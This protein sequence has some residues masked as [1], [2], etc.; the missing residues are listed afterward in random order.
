M[1]ELEELQIICDKDSP[2]TLNQEILIKAVYSGKDKIEYKFIIGNDGVWNTVQDFS[3]S[4]I[5]KWNPKEEGNYIIMVQGKQADSRKSFHC[6]VKKEYII[7]EKKK[8][9]LIDDIILEKECLM[10]GEKLEVE[11]IGSE[12]PLLFRF[13]H[14]KDKDWE[15]IKDYSTDNKLLYTVN[16]E[17]KQEIL[18]ECK[19]V[20]ST[21]VF[22]EFSTITFKAK[23]PNQ[24]EISNFKC[25]TK[26]L[27]VNE[28]LIFKVE[29]T[30]DEK[31]SLLYKFLKINKEGKAI[32]IQDYSSKN[33]VSFKETEEGEYKLLCMVRDMLSVKE[34]DDRALMVYKVK[35]YTNVKINKFITD[36]NSP[37]INGTLI[38]LKAEAEGGIELLY[39]YIIEGPIAYDSGYISES[40]YDWIPSLEG[41][42]ILTLMCKDKSF[43]GE[44]EERRTIK[45]T[46]DKKA[47]K[48]VKLV[49]IVVSNENKVLV[50]QPVNIKVLAEGGIKLKYSFTVYCNGE[51]KEEIPFS[52]SNWLNF[53][54][55]EKG[56]YQVEIKVKDKYTT[57]EY[58]SHTF[59]YLKA[60]EYIPGEIDYVLLPN[61]NNYLVD[62]IIDIEVIVQNT[63]NVLIRYVTKINGYEIEDT[64]FIDSK[65]LQINPKCSG[66]YT[67][68]MYAK[69]KKCE[70]EYDSKK[71]ISFYVLERA[72]IINTKITLDKEVV[73]VNKEITF[74]AE[75][76]GGKEVC[77]EFYIM[78][79]DNW[80]KVQSYSR[81]NR[82]TFIPFLKGNYKVMVLAKSFYKKVSYEDYYESSFQVV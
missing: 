10:V 15:I 28:E 16:N 4:S 44:C 62:D 37:Q 14:K 48:P 3:E 60:K 43:K 50:G 13:W 49:D 75:S 69:N 12:N 33:V 11:V 70:G 51:E 45:F 67:I 80:V 18:I 9:R 64:G 61:K 39:R 65:K 63:K 17:G 25:L 21:E 74:I 8:E 73:N 5:Y 66:K 42:Y 35:P 20:D 46:I 72:P 56:E 79:N 52:Y 81:K 34:Y 55:D 26:N 23:A 57:K 53:T 2:Q 58:D 40:S 54:P 22:D 27:L 38:K 30:I 32:C 71:K 6:I 77:Y 36:M 19:R 1:R 47:D 68:E 24:I 29:A 82:Y 59:V 7:K 41:D 31:R 78:E 76:N